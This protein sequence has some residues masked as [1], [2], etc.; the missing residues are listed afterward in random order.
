[1]NQ[2]KVWKWVDEFHTYIGSN[3]QYI[4]N[5]AEKY[6]YG[7][8]ISS[9]FVESTVNEVISK[10]MVKKQQM[11]WTQ[12]GAHRMIQVRTATLNNELRCTF[13][14]WYPNMKINSGEQKH[15]NAA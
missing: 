4:P 1:M 13:C 8:I 12:E 7:E 6:R 15:K 5:Y 10:R 2:I 14:K 3:R 11:R 9:S